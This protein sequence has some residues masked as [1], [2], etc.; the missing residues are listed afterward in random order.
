M[1]HKMHL[2]L[3]GGL[4][5]LGAVLLFTSGGTAFGGTSLFLLVF[6]GFCFAIM[7]F[8]MGGMGGMGGGGD[9]RGHQHGSDRPNEFEDDSRRW[10]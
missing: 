10:K 9:T 8:I 6:L 1:N 7:F 5:A 4:V 3:M 2:Y